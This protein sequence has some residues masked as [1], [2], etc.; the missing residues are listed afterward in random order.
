[1]DRVFIMGV[2]IDNL[3]L[4]EAVNRIDT[5]IEKGKPSL[6]VT[7]NPEI[8]LRAVK[9]RDFAKCLRGAA[10]V[11]A[12]GIG[13]VIAAAILGRPLKQRV[14]GIDLVT[15]LFARSAHR[16]YR[17]YLVGARPGIA[18]KAARNIVARY[19]GVEVVGIRHGYFDDDSEIIEDIRHKKPDIVLAALG[20]V[21]Q[22]TWIRDRL[23]GCGVPVGIGVGG[24]F[25]VFA[26]EAKRAPE[27]M[28][29]TGLEWLYRLIKQPSR[30]WRMIHLPRFLLA[31]AISRLLGIKHEY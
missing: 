12:D 2:G 11:T 27:W 5:Y 9:D 4:H 8:I 16:K 10:L 13:I 20:M 1:M 22:E 28:R 30:I 15:A 17:F 23:Q 6:V 18:D 14:T 26:G 3:D 19:P 31:I 25:D 29:R 24:S 21:R 7:A